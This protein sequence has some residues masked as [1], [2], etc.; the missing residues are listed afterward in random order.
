MSRLHSGHDEVSPPLSTATVAE[1]LLSSN[2]LES[3]PDAIVAVD[4]DGT[5]LQINSQTQELFG[6][7]RSE[8]IGQK[9]EM[10]VPERHRRQHHHHRENFSEA[11]K[12]RRMGAGLDLYGR[13]RSGSEFP[14]EISLSPI[15]TGDGSLVL[16]A[17]RDISDRK[18]IETE[19]RR[20]HEELELKSAQEI[21]EYRTRLASIIDFSEDAI[22]GKDLN[23]TITSWNRG[24]ERIYG[25]G[26]EEAVGKHI[27]L[28]AP[29]DRADERRLPAVKVSSTTNRCE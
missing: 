7:A 26:R 2:L 28:L 21:G 3:I 29:S 22:I 6:Y 14:V 19:L 1:V 13:R 4:A 20:V 15:S 10:L 23:G 24:A 11:P 25:Y 5:I 12:I 16:S 27:S 17:I 8:L 18:R 9:I